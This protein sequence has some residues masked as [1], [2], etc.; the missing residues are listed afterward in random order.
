LSGKLR[1]PRSIRKLLC[2]NSG[3]QQADLEIAQN[4]PSQRRQIASTVAVDGHAIQQ[5]KDW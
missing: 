3:A 2:A 1:P 4:R 5:P